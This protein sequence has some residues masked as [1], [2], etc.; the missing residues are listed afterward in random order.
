MIGV[1]YTS[2]FVL[3]DVLARKRL[4]LGGSVGGVGTNEDLSSYFW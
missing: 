1:P 3:S 4:K 2:F